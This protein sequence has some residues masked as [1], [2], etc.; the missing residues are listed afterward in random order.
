MLCTRLEF[1][2]LVFGWSGERASFYEESEGFVTVSRMGECWVVDSF[3]YVGICRIKNFLIS[4][5]NLFAWPEQFFSL[6]S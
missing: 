6:H 5:G 4:E 3:C 1:C 2:Q